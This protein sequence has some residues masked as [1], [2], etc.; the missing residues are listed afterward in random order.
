MFLPSL[1][2]R[3][4]SYFDGQKIVRVFVL[5]SENSCA[6]FFLYRVAAWQMPGSKNKVDPVRVWCGRLT[7]RHSDSH[8]LPS[9][10]VEAPDFLI[11]SV[12]DFAS[13]LAKQRP[14]SKSE[15]RI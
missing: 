15:T 7:E 2:R 14:G 12:A 5:F 11:Q 9:G 10:S 4:C 6:I 13:G 3:R 1:F 8:L